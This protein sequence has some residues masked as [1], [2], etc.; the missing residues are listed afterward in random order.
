MEEIKIGLK[1]SV[2]SRVTQSTT[3][4]FLKSGSLNVL[5]TPEMIRLIEQSAAELL[6]KNLPDGKTSV[7]ISMNIEHK[8]PT[9]IGLKI[10]AEVTI[11]K[12]DGRKITFSARVYDPISEIGSGTHERFIVDAEKFQSKA[13][14][15][16]VVPV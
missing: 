1:N 12:V 5:G 16:T 7:G 13:D 6:E 15:K 3:A 2:E 9:P 11:E 4:K 14:S 10:T 8:S